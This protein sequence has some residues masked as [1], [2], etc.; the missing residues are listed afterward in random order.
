M[1]SI[2]QTAVQCELK[3]ADTDYDDTR[4]S[5]YNLRKTIKPS[6]RARA[7][8]SDLPMRVPRGSPKKA[9]PIELEG[10][11]GHRVS[12]ESSSAINSL[13]P[14]VTVPEQDPRDSESEQ[15]SLQITPELTPELISDGNS[16]GSRSLQATPETPAE[17]GYHTRSI[18]RLSRGEDIEAPRDP[19]T[20]TVQSRLQPTP[21]ARS[22][23][24]S[25]SPSRR[26][27]R[28]QLNL[29]LVRSGY[30]SLGS[31]RDV[32]ARRWIYRKSC[33]GTRPLV[34]YWQGPRLVGI[35][36]REPGEWLFQDRKFVEGARHAAVCPKG[37][38]QIYQSQEDG[39][40]VKNEDGVRVPLWPGEEGF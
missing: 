17:I 40:H 29:I 24:A 14:T 31:L 20:T 2:I 3:K 15:D 5:R 10:V 27:A 6:W 7:G 39:V 4:P 23:S 38:D 22:R 28:Q 11:R 37:V 36:N 13:V 1:A 19:P 26:P 9:P 12:A 35:W 34:L 21:L 32:K 33:D 16:R 30:Q 25:A 8:C 18:P